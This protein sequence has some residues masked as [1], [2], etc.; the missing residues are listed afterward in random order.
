MREIIDLDI[1]VDAVALNEPFTFRT[2]DS[3]FCGSGDPFV[4]QSVAGGKPNLAT[5]GS[6]T[7]YLAE[8]EAAKAFGKGFT[9]GGREAVAEHDDVS[10]EGVLHIPGGVA[11]ARLPV[12]PCFAE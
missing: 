2:V 6:D 9:V 8:A 11:D 1:G 5:P 7:D 10:T 3:G 12:E 4:C